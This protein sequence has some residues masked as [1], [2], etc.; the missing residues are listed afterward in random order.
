M[1][2]VTSEVIFENVDDPA[3]FL[4]MHCNTLLSLAATLFATFLIFKR[5][6]VEIGNYKYYLFN[7]TVSSINYNL[8]PTF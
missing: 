6:P 3:Y 1:N 2:T 8:F 7:I 4:I 5:S